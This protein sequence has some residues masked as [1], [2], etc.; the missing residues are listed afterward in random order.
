MLRPVAAVPGEVAAAL[1]RVRLA[2][3]RV[4]LAMAVELPWLTLLPYAEDA[5]RG[6]AW[7]PFRLPAT[8]EVDRWIAA[9]GA[10]GL[11]VELWADGAEGDGDGAGGT[12]AMPVA[13]NYTE[14]DLLH[15]PLVVAKVAHFLL[16]GGQIASSCPWAPSLVAR[17]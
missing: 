14:D 4:R 3:G 12:L 15:V 8:A 2:A 10:E 6:L 1:A 9:I 17:S 16:L 7:V 13:A 5:E 11:P